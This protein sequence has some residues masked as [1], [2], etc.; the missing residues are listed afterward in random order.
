M[1]QELKAKQ[2]RP[3]PLLRVWIPSGGERSLGIPTI[4]DRVVQMAVL[5]V[6]G[7]IFEVD[8]FKWQYG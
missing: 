2:Y 6:A 5:L 7:P 4:R 1:Q 8:L 3:Q